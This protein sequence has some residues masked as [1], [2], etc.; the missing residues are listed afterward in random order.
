[1]ID[2][3][4]FVL[5]GMFGGKMCGTK[6]ISEPKTTRVWLWSDVAIAKS[7]GGIVGAGVVAMYAG[8]L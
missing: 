7:R 4:V 5:F 6:P 1:M 2:A 8:A 3:R